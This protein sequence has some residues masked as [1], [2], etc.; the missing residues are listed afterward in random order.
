MSTTSTPSPRSDDLVSIAL[1]HTPHFRYKEGDTF[2]GKRV[3]KSGA[4]LVWFGRYRA[5]SR[6]AIAEDI[7]KYARLHA[8]QIALAG[9]GFKSHQAS[10]ADRFVAQHRR[11][12]IEPAE[13]SHILS[14]IRTLGN[15]LYNNSGTATNEK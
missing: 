9:R 12:A 15:D 1:S 2:R 3:V 6:Y 7:A 11:T 8:S 10:A 13:R 5:P 14:L 4:F